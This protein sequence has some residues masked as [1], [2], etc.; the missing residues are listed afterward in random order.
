MTDT[1]PF[2][3]A[4]YTDAAAATHGLSIA[5]EHRPGVI[6]NVALLHR[7][8]HA[9]IEFPLPDDVEAAPVFTP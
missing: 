5:P 7:M 3:A 1:K 2:D 4:A 9:V 6:E 8:A